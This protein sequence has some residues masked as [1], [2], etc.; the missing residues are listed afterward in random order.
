MVYRKTEKLEL[1]GLSCSGWA[2]NKDKS[3]SASFCCFKR[4]SSLRV[5]SWAGRLQKC[6]S[7]ATA[8]RCSTFGK[9]ATRN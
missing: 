1:T 6:F 2:G 4:N 8:E 7:T 9:L 3:K 5:I